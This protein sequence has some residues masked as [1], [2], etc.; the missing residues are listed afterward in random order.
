M[1]SQK[2]NHST[3]KWGSP[4]VHLS[5]SITLEWLGVSD[6]FTPLLVTLVTCLSSCLFQLWRLQIKRTKWQQ[7]LARKEYWKILFIFLLHLRLLLLIL[8]RQFLLFL[9]IFFRKREEEEEEEE[10]QQQQKR[11]QEKKR[12]ERKQKEHQDRKE[13]YVGNQGIRRGTSVVYYSYHLWNA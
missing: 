13:R 4:G 3:L 8:L 6:N 7:L 1:P 11:Q 2:S 5:I 10:Q 9:I 12:E